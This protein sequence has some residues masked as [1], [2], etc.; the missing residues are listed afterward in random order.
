M[1]AYVQKFMYVMYEGAHACRRQIDARCLQ[2]S[3]T[4]LPNL[5][6]L[7]LARFSWSSPVIKPKRCLRLSLPP[8]RWAFRDAPG[9]LWTLGTNLSPSTTAYSLAHY[10]TYFLS[11]GELFGQ[12]TAKN[13]LLCSTQWLIAHLF[14][15]LS[16]L[17]P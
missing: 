14:P 9:C 16:K 5:P 2:S 8:D 13:T 3:S 17:P 4:S 12:G 1:C 6:K 10:F 7:E 15:V 11:L